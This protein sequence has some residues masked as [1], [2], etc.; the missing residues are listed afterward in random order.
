MTALAP[1]PSQLGE[2]PSTHAIEVRGLHRTY[3]RGSSAFHAVRG[4]DLDVPAGQITALLGTNGAGKTSTLEV[5]EGLATP[6]EGTVRVLGLDP[7]ADAPRVRPRLG[8]LL[9]RSGFP[10]DLTVREVL[11]M[12]AGTLTSPRSVEESLEIVSL[13]AKADTRVLSLSGGEQRRLDVACT[14]MGDPEV[15]I[16]DEPTT[17][18]DVERRNDVLQLVKGLRERGRAVLFSTHH[19]DEVEE[20]ADQVAVMHRGQIARR[21]TLADVIE[22]HPSTVSFATPYDGSGR[23]LELPALAGEVTQRLD[24]G[25]L[26]TVRTH[27]VQK[28]LH[29]L[30]TWADQHQVRLDQLRAETASLES[31]FLSIASETRTE[32]D[33]PEENR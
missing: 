29:R 12:W 22:G 4:V 31:V 18:M 21:G 24:R 5:I 17:G 8:V 15:V 2:Q 19:L 30:L 13:E 14:L 23:T 26:T 16:L 6:S 11:T 28:A 25:G 7:V 27:D 32:T 33:T 3:G 9:Q 1:S 10:G 20:L